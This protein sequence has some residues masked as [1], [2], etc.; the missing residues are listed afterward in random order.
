MRRFGGVFRT[1]VLFICSA[2]WLGC[3]GPSL[4]PTHD[5]TGKVTMDGQ[6]VSDAIVIFNAMEG[7]P[8]EYRS[9]TA[10]IGPDG[11][12]SLKE[13]YEGEYAVGVVPAANAASIDPE[14]AGAAPAAPPPSPL[15]KYSSGAKI[16]A[17]VRADQTS[18]T[19]DLN[20]NPDL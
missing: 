3:G 16:R 2:L 9:K 11:S 20:S 17:T 1:P 7:I 15:D 19:F 5:I 4:P 14:N 13:V 8:S 12:F 18:F 10:E 6:P